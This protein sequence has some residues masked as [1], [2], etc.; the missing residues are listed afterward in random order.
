MNWHQEFGTGILVPRSCY[1]DFKFRT[2]D[3]EFRNIYTDI[4][5]VLQTSA[6]EGYVDMVRHHCS[7]R[8]AF[9]PMF[10]RCTQLILREIKYGFRFGFGMRSPVWLSQKTVEKH[11]F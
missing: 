11:V 1:R 9:G 3:S 2:N 7:M 8:A 10:S 4:E 5:G 6:P